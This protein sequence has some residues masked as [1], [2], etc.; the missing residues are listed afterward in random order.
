MG[1]D[2]RPADRQSHTH[3]VRLG[4]V[5]RIEDAVDVVL[6]DAASG[7]F[8]RHQ[9]MVGI[10]NCGFH[11]QHPRATAHPSIA[12]A[13]FLT[14][15]KITCCSWPLWPSTRGSGLVSPVWTTIPCACS[16]PRTGRMTS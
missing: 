12:S 7:V 3:P 8:D 11:P 13:A 6:I 5:E 9:D 10:V 1:F 14:R 2:D 4:R 15:F 16:S